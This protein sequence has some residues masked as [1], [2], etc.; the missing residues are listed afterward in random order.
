LGFHQPAN[1][2]G[3]IHDGMQVR[4]SSIGD[5]IVRLEVA[6]GQ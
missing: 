2:G 1:N 4:V 5:V 6:D 3:P